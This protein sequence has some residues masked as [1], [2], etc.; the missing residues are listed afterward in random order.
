MVSI[1]SLLRVSYMTSIV[2]NIVSLTAFEI[3]IAKVLWPR[4]RTLQGY[5]RSKMTVPIDSTWG[6][7]I[8]LLLTPLSYLS[9]VWIFDVLWRKP[10]IQ[11]EINNTAKR[12]GIMAVLHITY[13]GIWPLPM[14]LTTNVAKEYKN[15]KHIK[16]IWPKVVN[17]QKTRHK[18]SQIYTRRH[19]TTE[20]PLAEKISFSKGAL[21]P[22]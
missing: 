4:S 16:I 1:G 19:C 6:L 20:T 11:H 5:P 18:G 3:L 9:Q 21:D 7:R 8:R 22:I 17:E 12:C 10:I 15:E 2:S 13:Y 14:T